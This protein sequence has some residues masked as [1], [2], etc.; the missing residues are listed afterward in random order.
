MEIKRVNKFHI[1]IL[2]DS[3]P[4]PTPLQRRILEAIV[5][6]DSGKRAAQLL[7]CSLHLINEHMG[8]LHK[9]WDLHGINDVIAFALEKGILDV[10]YQ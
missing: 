2:P 3:F 4:L 6:G 10:P 9:K 1:S 5:I 8:R 7:G